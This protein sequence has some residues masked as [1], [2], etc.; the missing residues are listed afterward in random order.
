MQID[1]TGRDDHACGVEKLGI[2][3]RQICANFRNS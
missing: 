3:S 2:G 1:E